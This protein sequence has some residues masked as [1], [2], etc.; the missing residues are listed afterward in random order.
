[1]SDIAAFEHNGVAV[2][3]QQFYAVACDPRRS[4]AVEACAGA[5]KTWM[6]VCGTRP[7]ARCPSRAPPA[8]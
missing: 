4:V 3:R 6:L 2:R 5:G 7:Q 1:M 8:T